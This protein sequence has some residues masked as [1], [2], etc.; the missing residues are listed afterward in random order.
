[1]RKNWPR[2]GQSQHLAAIAR[3]EKKKK[4][5]RTPQTCAIEAWARRCCG[6]PTLFFHNLRRTER[7]AS[8]CTRGS[9]AD[10]TRRSIRSGHKRRGPAFSL[11]RSPRPPG[12][13]GRRYARLTTSDNERNPL[14]LT[15]GIADKLRRL[16]PFQLRLSRSVASTTSVPRPTLRSLLSVGCERVEWKSQFVSSL[17]F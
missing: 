9:N 8:Q 12:R 15:R 6:S 14:R 13:L 4:I 10:H 5:V 17:C 2:S 3:K 11:A 1:M 7:S 16:Q